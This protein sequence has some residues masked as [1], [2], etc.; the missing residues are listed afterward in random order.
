MKRAF[1]FGDKSMEAAVKRVNDVRRIAII[2][3]GT[4]GRGIAAD[5]LS[6]TDYEVTLLDV[7]R[8]ALDRVGTYFNSRWENDVHQQRLRAQDADANAR[9]NYTNGDGNARR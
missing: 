7:D 9:T 4:M 6:K 1:T 8:D 3:A 2:G 5:V